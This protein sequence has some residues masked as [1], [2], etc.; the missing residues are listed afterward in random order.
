M[1]IP[2]VA[3][4]GA[5]AFVVLTCLTLWIIAEAYRRPAENRSG[6]DLKH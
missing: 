2:A 6:S 5:T 3:F 4:L 1:P